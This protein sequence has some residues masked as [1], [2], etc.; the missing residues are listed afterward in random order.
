M[1][2]WLRGPDGEGEPVVELI[3]DDGW[4]WRSDH[5]GPRGEPRS[6]MAEL[7]GEDAERFQVADGVFFLPGP[8]P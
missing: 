5:F 1:K 8:P 2:R 6:V 4:C 3:G 7:L